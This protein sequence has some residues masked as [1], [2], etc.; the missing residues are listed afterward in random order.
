[1]KVMELL[2]NNIQLTRINIEKTKKI[3]RI[4]K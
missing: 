2:K 3:A 1:M 4:D